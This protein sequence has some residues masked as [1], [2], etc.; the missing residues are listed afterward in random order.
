MTVVVALAAALLALTG[1]DQKRIE[2]LE[3]GVATEA[4]VRRQFGEPHTT[5]TEP[6]GSKTFEYSRQP[7]G[8]QTYMITI[9]PDGKMSS[10]RQVLN[11]R[12]FATI[13]PG[14]DD[15]EVRRLLGKPAS[16]KKYDLKPDEEHWEWRWRQDAAA[17]LFTVTF[18]G[19]GKVASTAVGDDPRETQVPG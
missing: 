9:G 5:Y 16:V 1:C 10:L 15:S 11:A 7:E 13:V 3:E 14:M 18:D 8:Q 17:K 19:R 2:K 6:G 4:D 12:V